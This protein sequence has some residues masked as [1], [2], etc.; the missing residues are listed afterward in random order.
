ME[1]SN[2]IEGNWDVIVAAMKKAA[3]EVSES[4]G[5][6]ILRV[7]LNEYGTVDSYWTQE[8]ITSAAVRNGTAIKIKDF[9][10]GDYWSEDWCEGYVHEGGAENDLDYLLWYHRREEEESA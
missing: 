3:Q 1:W 6:S 2:V 8:N 7:E 4:N 10:G 9:Q 5:E